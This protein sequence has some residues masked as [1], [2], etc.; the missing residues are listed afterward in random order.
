[1]RSKNWILIITRLYF[2]FMITRKLKSLWSQG[3]W[4]F[5][6]VFTE[7][8]TDWWLHVELSPYLTSKNYHFWYHF[9]EKIHSWRISILKAHEKYII[10]DIQINDILSVHDQSKACNRQNIVY[11]KVTPFPTSQDNWPITR[12]ILHLICA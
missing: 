12:F 5:S 2:T 10:Q 3:L 11:K 9:W 4:R 8:N 1:M 6:K 7:L